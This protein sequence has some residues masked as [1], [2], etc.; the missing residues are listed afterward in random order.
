MVSST[1]LLLW[2]KLQ[3]TRWITFVMKTFL[4]YFFYMAVKKIYHQLGSNA[5]NRKGEN[6][7]LKFLSHQEP[8][9]SLYENRRIVSASVLN[10]FLPHLQCLRDSFPNHEGLFFGWGNFRASGS[11][12]LTVF[13]DLIEQKGIYISMENPL[14]GRS[15]FNDSTMRDSGYFR[16]ALY[17]TANLNRG[18]SSLPVNSNDTRLRSVLRATKTTLKPYRKTGEHI[19]YALQV[20]QDTSLTGLEVFSAAQHDLVALRCY[21]SR[22]IILTAHPAMRKKNR[23]DTNISYLCLKELCQNMKIP[24]HEKHEDSSVFLRN[25]WCVVCHSSGFAVDAVLAGVPAITLHH[26]SF[27]YPICSHDLSEVEN[28]KMPDRIPWFSRLAYCQWTLEEIKNGDAWRHFQPSV[29][30]LLEKK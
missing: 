21:T 2:V 4:P 19:L 20:P 29:E 10:T 17:N 26:G 8:I 3:G 14:I 6:R 12:S 24:F 30:R 11:L 1:R 23:D 18:D 27:V 7:E 28:P 9:P 15:L 25:C 22:P 16:I 13:P 5:R